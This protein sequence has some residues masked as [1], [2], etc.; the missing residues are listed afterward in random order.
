MPRYKDY[1]SIG[2]NAMERADSLIYRLERFAEDNY[3]EEDF[4]RSSEDNPSEDVRYAPLLRETEL[5]LPELTLRHVF[6]DIKSRITDEQ[7]ERIDPETICARAVM[8]YYEDWLDSRGGRDVVLETFFYDM[9]KGCAFCSDL[10]AAVSSNW[11][12]ELTQIIYRLIERESEESFMQSQYDLLDFPDVPGQTDSSDVSDLEARLAR[13]RDT[14]SDSFES[15]QDDASYNLGLSL[16]LNAADESE[17]DS[18]LAEVEACRDHIIEL[19]K[20][21]PQLAKIPTESLMAVRGYSISG[22]LRLNYA[23]RNPEKADEDLQQ[24]GSYIHATC[25]ALV[26]L[27]LYQGTVYRGTNLPPNIL[28]QYTVGSIV[29]EA[30]FLSTTKSEAVL[31]EFRDAVCFEIISTSG[32]VIEAIAND[33]SEEEVLFLPGTAFKVTARENR[34][35][36]VYICMTQL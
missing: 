13:L 30:S 27:P 17:A 28:A 19:Q 8:S 7:Y 21:N 14:D 2:R 9:E 22:Y 20:S 11:K 4:D 6:P 15:P 34:E 12:P 36:Y 1:D 25:S 24:Y 32:A 35:K 10:R 3:S 31:A 18:F 26:Q 33:P 23:L 16:S 5:E 29:T